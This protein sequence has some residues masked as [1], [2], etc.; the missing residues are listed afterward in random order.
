MKK[1]LLLILFLTPVTLFG[2]ITI[3]EAS[4]SNGTTILLPNGDSPD[5]IELYNAGASSVNMS[6][7]SL[8]DNPDDL[9]KW[10][11]PSVIIQ[12]LSFLTVF[13]TG[14]PTVNQAE[15]YET[16]VFADSI[17]DYSIP[18]AEIAN[19]NSSTFNSSSWLSGPA[20]IGYGDGDDATDLI[21]PCSSIYSRIS[22][23]C[24]NVMAISE[25]ILD[26]DYDDGF[27]AYLNGVEIARSGLSGTPP[28]WDEPS[29]DHEATLYQGA[30]ISVFNLD[31]AVIQSALVIG[32]NVLAIEVHNTSPGSSDI[33][34][35]PYLSFGYSLPGT[36]ASG[37][38]HPYFAAVNGGT[39]ES[40][41]KINT[42]GEIIYLSNSTNN[43]IDSLV[44][45]DLE[46]NMSSGKYPDGGAASV[47]FTVPTPNASNNSSSYFGGYENQP[48]IVNVGGVFSGSNLTVSVINNSVSGGVLR[49]T[50]NGNNPDTTSSLLTG[51]LTLDSN[52]VLK[53]ACFSVGTNLLPSI[54][55]TETFLFS[56]DFELPIVLLTIDSLDL[57]GASGIF[58]KWWTDWKKPCVVEYFDKNGVKQFETRSSV[59]P[60]GGAGG[61]R[62]YP[63]HSVTIEPANSVFGEGEP[64]HYPIIPE[65]PYIN[66]Y[67]ALYL[68][69][70]SLGWN[71][72]PQ[73]DALFTRMM[74]KTNVNY[75]AYTP[76]VVFLNGNY[77][78]VY[79]LREKANEGY[80]ENNYGNDRDS[81][82]LLSISFF[83]G[84]GW[85]RTVKGHDSS[86]YSMKNFIA[87]SNPLSPSYFAN[88]HKKLD[89]YN[90]AD[91]M[92]G[93]NWFANT[94][95]IHNN[96]K[97]ARTRTYDNKWRFFL[98]DLEYGLGYG[99]IYDYNMFD[100]F[101]DYSDSVYFNGN[102]NPFRVIYNGLIQNPE[103]KNY[104]I[105][106]YADLMNTTFQI[107]QY[108]EIA[109]SMHN[110]LLAD[111]P[112]S[113]LLWSGNAD[114][115]G[116]NN[117]YL[118]HLTQ[119]ANRNPVVRGQIVS[120]FNLVDT[121]IVT[122]DVFPAGAGYIKISTIVPENLPWTGVYFDGVPVKITAI[123]NPGYTFQNWV[124]N[125]TL[126]AGS[127][128]QSSI[129]QNIDQ[130]D[131]FKAV[132]IGSPEEPS[133]TISEINYNPD[134]TV[135]GGN[136][137]ELH[138]FGS[139]AMDL[140]AWHIKTKNHY[141]KFSFE[142]Q[143]IIPPNGY[144]V[145]CENFALFNSMYPQVQNVVGGT[146]FVW[147]NK[148]DSIRVFNPFDSMALVAVYSDEAPYPKCADGWGRT[149]ENKHTSTSLLDENSWFCGCLGGSPG[150]AYEEC[151]EPIYVSE[152]SYNNINQIY[153]PGDWIE[154]YN[155]TSSDINLLGYV[156]K[157]S[158]ND[159]EYIFPAINLAPDAFL[160]VGNDLTA[161][162]LRNPLVQNVIG[163]FN[164]GLAPKD[165]IR[166]YDNNGILIS[167]FNYDT[168][169]PWSS[170]PTYQDF[171]NEYN[172]YEGY[173]DPNNGLSWFI[174]C[175]GGSPGTKYLPCP[176]LPDGEFAFLYP[177][178]SS[179]NITITIDNS[180]SG[181]GLIELEIYNLN[182]QI[183]Y[184]QLL[185]KV[186]ESVMSVE[187][188]VT[189]FLQGVYYVKIIQADQ[190]K[191]LPFV[192]L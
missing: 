88:C 127:L 150:K 76:A 70:G 110:E 38:V 14:K 93:E 95:W 103:F 143:T 69:N 74:R 161:F 17:W 183:V 190:S 60:D 114:M 39:L 146:G 84:A 94:D 46:P 65:K 5:W 73:R 49:Y 79:E 113:L 174:G 27:V 10:V 140:T 142:D 1:L 12:P 144:L 126:P 89:L 159:H 132:F 117:M 91:Y 184:N 191:T 163:Q 153:N 175:E 111:Y 45:L 31:L 29:A 83:Y 6:G 106:R 104:Y 53:V 35:R 101:Q 160:V 92:A 34:C 15:H 44:V 48:T 97:M 108:G 36:F 134:A 189:N 166:L 147:S 152:F 124:Q 4:N 64:I 170:I 172:F 81:L 121:V 167:S 109:D 141:D 87:T 2:Q 55:A 107:E 129:T 63:Q 185:D 181:A 47:V 131:L 155:N 41:F 162:N 187:I 179:S 78:G 32:T 120:H 158:K 40:N 99:T 138:N 133:L 154:F 156:F 56:E 43:L 33:T 164:F 22:F 13:A 52:S 139:T 25:A 176:V 77:F 54:I 192:K 122:L 66:D 180:T 98:Q 9:M 16:S 123:A 169:L 7:Y 100:W 24:S 188:D 178:P 86:F 8:S 11:F 105:N 20:S 67:Y 115:S 37:T 51:P 119:F 26:I 165:G 82:D 171:T 125:M 157:D 71:W 135:D 75:Q 42:S 58:D 136:W 118:N 168:I 21:G 28:L 149:L 128:S 80:F 112:R 23:Q 182:G 62:S 61:S 57:Y 50:T 96:M 186:Q 173:I 59:K 85:L 18:N 137:I 151:E 130:N 90:F 102:P 148:Y 72:Y 116:Y 3:N 19:W 30:P 145:V 68:R 177:N